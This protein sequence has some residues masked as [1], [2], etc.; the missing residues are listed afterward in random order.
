DPEHYAHIASFFR[1]APE[2]QCDA[3]WRALG[4]AVEE[5]M[6]QLGPT[7]DVWLSAEG[8]GVIWVHLRVDLRPKT[9]TTI[10][11][12]TPSM[13]WRQMAREK[14]RGLGACPLR[15]MRGRS[16]LDDSLGEEGTLGLGVRVSRR[17]AGW[18][19]RRSG[20]VGRLAQHPRRVLP[21]LPSSWPS[22]SPLASSLL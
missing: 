8:N 5:R 6:S 3:L 20:G 10:R 19:A 13:A 1:H 14:V 21:R 15:Q 11:I 7:D 4:E 22:R 9:T 12:E 2:A 16:G 17:D 18:F